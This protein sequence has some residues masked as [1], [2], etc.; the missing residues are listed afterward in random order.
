MQ[1]H[2]QVPVNYDQIM[3]YLPKQQGAGPLICT[4]C[5]WTSSENG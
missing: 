3:T 5:C 2:T 4:R 1:V